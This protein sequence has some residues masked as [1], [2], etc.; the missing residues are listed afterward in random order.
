MPCS[1]ALFIMLY[2]IRS[3]T[4]QQQMEVSRDEGFVQHCGAFD[5]KPYISSPGSS[6]ARV[7]GN[8]PATW[9]HELKL[10]SYFG[11]AAL[12]HLVEVHLHHSW[13]LGPTLERIIG[14]RT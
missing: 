12:V 7:P 14:T 13:Q 9:L 8:E 1:S 2:A 4:L 3:F 11:E 10:A 6:T 5:R